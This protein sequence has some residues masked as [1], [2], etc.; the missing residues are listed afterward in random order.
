MSDLFEYHDEKRGRKAV[1]ELF[2]IVPAQFDSFKH[3]VTHLF[4]P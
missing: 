1:D 2:S 4:L 3:Q